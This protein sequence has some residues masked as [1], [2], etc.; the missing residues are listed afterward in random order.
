MEHRSN[1][2]SNRF[3]ASGD[4]EGPL[5]VCPKEPREEPPAADAPSAAEL[6]PEEVPSAGSGND[7]ADIVMGTVARYASIPSNTGTENGPCESSC[8]AANSRQA[9]WV[10]A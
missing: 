5:V 4:W 6:R 1:A 2:P 10:G 8:A 9:R 3:D 7:L